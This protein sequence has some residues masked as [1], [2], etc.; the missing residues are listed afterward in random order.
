MEARE[1]REDVNL[2]EIMLDTGA[3]LA[4]M[5]LVPAIIQSLGVSPTLVGAVKIALRSRGGA[6]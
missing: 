3:A 2:G 6:E 1:E 4:S 5:I